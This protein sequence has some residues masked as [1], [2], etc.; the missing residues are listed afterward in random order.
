MQMVSVS[1]EGSDKFY[2]LDYLLSNIGMLEEKQRSAMK[3]NTIF[4]L[5]KL[6]SWSY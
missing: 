6:M 1:G 5:S 4:Y 2:S 3:L